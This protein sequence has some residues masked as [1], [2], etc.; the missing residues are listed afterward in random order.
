MQNIVLVGIGG[1]IGTILR[2]SLNNWVYQ[3]LAYPLFPYGTMIVN[4]LG[5]L[6][7]GFLG[8]LAEFHEVFTPTLRLFIFIGI[9][10]GFTTFSSFGYDTFG[11]LRG[12]QFLLAF[13]NVATQVF[14]GIGAVWVGFICARIL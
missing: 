10:G 2:Y 1:F 5:C 12:G 4:I 9:L 3:L 7:I 11:L 13:I 8:G 6:A 14:I